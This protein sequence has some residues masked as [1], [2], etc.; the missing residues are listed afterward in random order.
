MELYYTDWLLFIVA[1]LVTAYVIFSK[2]KYEKGTK[3]YAATKNLRIG[4]VFLVWSIDFGL[5]GLI[6]ASVA[7]LCGIFSAFNGKVTFGLLLASFAISS[8]IFTFF[9]MKPFLDIFS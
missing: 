5:V 4:I 2:N 3:I 9:R 6:L 7:F 1:I 8:A